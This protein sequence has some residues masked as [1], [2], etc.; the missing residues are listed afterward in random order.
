MMNPIKAMF[1]MSAA[2]DKKRRYL[3][4]VVISVDAKRQTLKATSEQPDIAV[5]ELHAGHRLMRQR[6]LDISAIIAPRQHP[7]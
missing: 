3:P 2:S 1:F 6:R 7:Y 5:E 4:K